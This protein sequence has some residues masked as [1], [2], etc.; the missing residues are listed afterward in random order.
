MNEVVAA[1]RRFIQESQKRLRT[2][3]EYA[4]LDEKGRQACRDGYVRGYLDALLQANIQEKKAKRL[5]LGDL[6]GRAGDAGDEWRK[7]LDDVASQPNQ[8][9]STFEQMFPG[10]TEE[11]QQ[12]MVEEA[13]QLITREELPEEVNQTA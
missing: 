2:T 13:A 9:H 7:V 3:T 11:Q 5:S 12:A 6:E 10:L 4:D 1:M 8:E